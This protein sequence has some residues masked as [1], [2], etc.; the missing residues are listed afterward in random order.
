MTEIVPEVGQDQDAELAEK[1]RAGDKAAFEA[2]VRKYQ[3]PIFSFAFHFFRSPDVAEDIAQ[4]TFLRAYRFLHTYDSSRKFVTWLYS[5]AR[6][7]C[8]DKHRERARKEHVAIDDVPAHYLCSDRLD[9]D[10]LGMLETK[11]NRRALVDAIES[12]PEKYK[13]P[14]ILCYLHGLPY[15]EISDILGI[16]L[17]NTKIRIFRAKKLLLEAL[18][19]TEEP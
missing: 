16:S 9:C 4:E 17:N 14:I 8:I 12:L 5:V 13:T 18:G 3:G 11:E 1:A 15:Q 7:L 6:N 2:L 10:P 19:F